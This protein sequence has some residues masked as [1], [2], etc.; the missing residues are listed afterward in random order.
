DGRNDVVVSAGPGGGPRVRVLDGSKLTQIKSTD[1]AATGAMIADYFAYDPAFGGG[2]SVAVVDQNGD[3]VGEIVTGSGP[4]G[5]PVVRIF[6]VN[7][8]VKQLTEFEPFD[9]SFTH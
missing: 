4:G 1:L 9:P 2:V 6:D 7:G 5:P 3:G 8:G